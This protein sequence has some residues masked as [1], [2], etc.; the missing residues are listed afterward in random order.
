MRS[1]D[2]PAWDVLWDG[3]LTFYE[4]VL[5]PGV[6]EAT[7]VRL[8]E[9]RDGMLG[10]VAEEDDGAVVGFAHVVVHASTW[11]TDTCVYFEELFVAPAARGVRDRPGG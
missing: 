4:T 7:S 1:E 11:S 10:I 3:Y 5:E 2:R 6:T 9:G 8:C